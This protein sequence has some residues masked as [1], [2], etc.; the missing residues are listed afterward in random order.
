M[1]AEV[2]KELMVAVTTIFIECIIK[3]FHC[4]VPRIHLKEIIMRKVV[5]D[6]NDLIQS[7][8]FYAMCVI[9]MQHELNCCQFN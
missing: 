1:H 5:I 2:K 7:D 6:S 3:S 4:I 9:S 8:I